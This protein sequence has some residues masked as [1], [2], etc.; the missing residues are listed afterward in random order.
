MIDIVG[1]LEGVTPDN[2]GRLLSHIHQFSDE[3]ME[4]THDYIQWVFPTAQPSQS[5]YNAPVLSPFDI[6]DLQQSKRA[7]ANLK[8]S[9]EWFS[10][11]LSRHNYWI[12][13]Y[14]HNH[15]RITRVITSLRLLAGD[16]DANQFLA[17]ILELIKGKE[18]QIGQKP[19]QF[20]MQ[21]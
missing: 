13:R 7:I 11:F 21:A 10:G 17:S 16:D 12:S 6:E 9:A 3:Q 15:L 1:F 19:I 14:N 4:T 5:N 2:R 20:W 18:G 8:I